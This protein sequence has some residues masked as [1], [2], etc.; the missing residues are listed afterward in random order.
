MLCQ[1]I[2]KWFQPCLTSLQRLDLRKIKKIKK[3]IENIDKNK[4]D[5]SCFAKQFPNDSNPA[6]HLS[7]DLNSEKYKN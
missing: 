6:T 4:S 5:H 1:T 3:I 7:K 2:S